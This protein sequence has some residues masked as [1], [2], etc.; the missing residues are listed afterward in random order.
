MSTVLEMIR[1]S[2]IPIFIYKNEGTLAFTGTAVFCQTSEPVQEGRFLTNNM[3]FMYCGRNDFWSQAGLL[4]CQI[5][6]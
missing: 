5:P 1:G 4:F 2:E 3:Y 6:G